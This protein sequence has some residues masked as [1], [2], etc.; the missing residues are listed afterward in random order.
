MPVT[1]PIGDVVKCSQCGG[2]TRSLSRGC[3]AC[4]FNGQAVEV[5]TPT[6]VSDDF[7][8]HIVA[9]EAELNVHAAP[10]GGASC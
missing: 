3:S 8:A 9:L 10:L 1:L 4:G 6:A 2:Q 7:D 5:A